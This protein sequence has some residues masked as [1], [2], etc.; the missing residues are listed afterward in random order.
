MIPGEKVVSR[1]HRGTIVD[2]LTPIYIRAPHASMLPCLNNHTNRNVEDDGELY[3][4]RPTTACKPSLLKH[5][6]TTE[7]NEDTNRR[8]HIYERI[9][10]T[11]TVVYIIIAVY[12]CFLSF[13]SRTT[14]TQLG[15]N[16]VL[17]SLFC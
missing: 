17:C 1:P 9:Y 5:L 6:V 12:A 16:D 7:E 8:A 14:G 13:M 15:Q 3:T 2:A 4:C 11:A 10:S